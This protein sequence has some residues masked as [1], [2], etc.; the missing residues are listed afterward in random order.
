MDKSKTKTKNK[1]KSV[2]IYIN[3]LG[4]NTQFYKNI[5]NENILEKIEE[6]LSH[7]QIQKDK[8]FKIGDKLYTLKDIK[9]IQE[10][11]HELKSHHITY[12]LLLLLKNKYL[13]NIL[14]DLYLLYIINLYNID[15]HIETV[16]VMCDPY[17]QNQV[18]N[19]VT[20]FCNFERYSNIS[21]MSV[22]KN[23][24]Y[25]DSLNYVLKYLKKPD[26]NNVIVIGHSY[27]G[28]IT[29]KIATYLYTHKDTS[30]VSNLELNKLQMA[31]IGSIYIPPIIK[32]P[33]VKIHHYVYANDPAYTR[34][35]RIK[36]LTKYPNL[37][38]MKPTHDSFKTNED[39]FKEVLNEKNLAAHSNYNIIVKNI[40]KNNNTQ[41]DITNLN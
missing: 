13:A 14:N 20:Y 22:T 11:L 38:V 30:K 26:Y 4:C 18:K 27:G 3:G 35:S 10:T 1:N 15:T 9:D 21:S 39:F 29:S 17:T 24:Y 31:T 25:E 36:D 40:L 32:T 7:L 28:S 34:C 23:K 5:L 6:V 37:H 12:N 41:I 2:L 8:K 19:I 16:H 33:N